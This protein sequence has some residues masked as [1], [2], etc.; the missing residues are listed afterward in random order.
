[1]GLLFFFASV[2]HSPLASYFEALK[3]MRA[4]SAK[5]TMDDGLWTLPVELGASRLSVSALGESACHRN[6]AGLRRVSIASIVGFHPVGH[7]V[8]TV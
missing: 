2:L 6:W 7:A 8:C 4:R 1:M 3:Q 5:L